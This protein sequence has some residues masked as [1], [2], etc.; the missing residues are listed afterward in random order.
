MKN[1]GREAPGRLAH[2]LSQPA[3]VSVRKAI[4]IVLVCIALV[5]VPCFMYHRRWT[6][7]EKR[8]RVESKLRRSLGKNFNSDNDPVVEMLI[9]M[10]V[11]HS[12]ERYL[13]IPGAVIKKNVFFFIIFI[14]NK[15]RRSRGR[16][17]TSYYPGI[18]KFN[19]NGLELMALRA[20][21]AQ[22]DGHLPN[23]MEVKH[24]GLDTSRPKVI[25]NNRGYV[26]APSLNLI[27][28]MAQYKDRPVAGP[29]PI[30]TM[31]R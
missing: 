16:R 18:G 4:F 8:Q 7:E 14:F 11:T 12:T 17:Y 5:S 26:V 2:F 31:N 19:T 28:V 15:N 22:L 1:W 13:K 21:H 25:T 6:Q 23:N 27:R 9:K 30:R 20:L 3:G 24:K 29:Y 10:Y